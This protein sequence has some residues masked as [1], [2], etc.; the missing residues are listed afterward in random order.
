MQKEACGLEGRL[1][2]KRGGRKK[3]NPP[4]ALLTRRAEIN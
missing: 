1:G 3:G 4:R 2:G